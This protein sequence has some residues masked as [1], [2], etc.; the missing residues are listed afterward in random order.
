MDQVAEILLLIRFPY[1]V[2]PPPPFPSPIYTALVVGKGTQSAEGHREKDEV[3]TKKR[4]FS[5]H[6]ERV[7]PKAR[8]K[9]PSS[10]Q[11]S[12]YSKHL[13][14]GLLQQYATRLEIAFKSRI[15]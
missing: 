1:E 6:L 8:H 5:S 14:Y 15:N 13:S 9:L 12:K 3:K 4:F 11:G 2:E 10:C 7:S